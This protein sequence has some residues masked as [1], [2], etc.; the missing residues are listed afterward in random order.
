MNDDSRTPEQ[1]HQ[2]P[3]TGRAP[4]VEQ[5]IGGTTAVRDNLDA[6]PI[7]IYPR[8]RPLL[9]GEVSEVFWA[10]GRGYVRLIGRWVARADDPRTR[11]FLPSEKFLDGVGI[12]AISGWSCATFRERAW[13]RTIP[14][15]VCEDPD[16][17]RASLRGTRRTGMSSVKCIDPPW[18]QN[19]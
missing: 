19:S 15:L 8:P 9:P 10:D 16:Q 11:V 6:E 3:G 4:E 5:P 12:R 7:P 1:A 2:S 18:R 17:T 13:L 14:G